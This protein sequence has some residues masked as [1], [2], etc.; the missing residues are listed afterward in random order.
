MTVSHRE[1]AYC[2]APD[3]VKVVVGP[4]TERRVVRLRL[5]YAATEAA[6]DE[7]ATLLRSELLFVEQQLV[8][9]GLG[10]TDVIARVAATKRVFSE[11]FRRVDTVATSYRRR[12]WLEA[13]LGSSVRASFKQAA[14]VLL[15]CCCALSTPPGAL[16]SNVPFRTVYPTR[17]HALTASVSPAR[18]PRVPP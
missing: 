6:T 14:C 5:A 10:L 7:A 18:R 2:S 16:H 3:A 8:S 9:E 4:D 11:A 1:A 15:P 17:K 12:L 13:R